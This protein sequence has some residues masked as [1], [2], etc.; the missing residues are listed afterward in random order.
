MSGI[1]AFL[2]FISCEVLSKL[3][4]FF[5]VEP[6]IFFMPKLNLYEKKI[7]IMD[8]IKSL[9]PKFGEA[10]LKEIYNIL[11]IMHD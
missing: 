2:F 11:L 5:E 3:A 7:N 9:L 1:S 8:D 4:N 10:K 6:M